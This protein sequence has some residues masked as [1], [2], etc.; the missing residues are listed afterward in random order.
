MEFLTIDELKKGVD[1]VMIVLDYEVVESDLHGLST[2]L[3]MISSILGNSSLIL[4]SAKYHYL[5]TGRKD[6]ESAALYELAESL[7]KNLHY[8]ITS[9]QS[10]LRIEGNNFTSSKFP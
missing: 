5:K 8:R 3:N 7:N 10:L 9:L 4:G 6:A 2:H 1:G